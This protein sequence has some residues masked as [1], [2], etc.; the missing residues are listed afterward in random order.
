MI[1]RNNSN[2]QKRALWAV[3]RR[4]GIQ[5]NDKD[6]LDTDNNTKG[7]VAKR[8]GNTAEK[9]KDGRDKKT[10]KV[11][12]KKHSMVKRV[13]IVMA[14]LII[15]S[16][17]VFGYKIISAGDKISVA[18]RSIFAQIK[19][20]F[21][22]QGNVLAGEEEGRINV[23]LIA[24]GGKG[25]KGENLADTIMVASIDPQTN[26]AALL[27][28]PRDLYV[29]VPGRDYYSK[30]NAVHAYGESQK[31][32]NGPVL[33]EGLVEDITGLPIHYYVRV[34]FTAFKSIIDSIGGVN[35]AIDN[36]FFDYWHKIS[37]P[38]GTEKMNGE[39]ALAYVRA[40]YIEGPEGGDF[41]RTARQQQVL[42]AIREKVF[43]VQTAFDFSRLNNILNSLSDNIRTDMQLW[44][45]K[46]FYEMSRL[47]KPKQVHSEVLTSGPK[48]ELTGATE[49]LGGTPASV[50]KPR[51]GDYSEIRAI[52]AS[53]LNEQD[54]VS[55]AE[56][57]AVNNEDNQNNAPS[58]TP[59]NNPSPTPV[60]SVEV[61]KSALEIRNG[62]LITGLAKKTSDDL[63]KQDYEVEKI[64]NAS[65]QERNTTTVYY[66]SSEQE[67]DAEDVASILGAELV[68]SL[69]A[70]VNST[71][72][73]VLIIL[74]YD[75]E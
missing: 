75:Q 21:L 2:S 39:R 69:P 71:S 22:S 51:T 31:E 57:Q 44:E 6:S 64:G 62:T 48:G 55:G 42:L 63:S 8:G 15:L 20:L 7:K 12:R 35:I 41:A 68:N 14:F 32:N 9:N 10:V 3:Q 25:H 73:D 56:K 54:E 5:N 30:I 11:A 58:P 27:S 37:F 26:E 46:R 66:S 67:N 4:Y 24:I 18:E 45:M 65:N 23:L 74:G 52:A 16:I 40:R 43:S 13:F 61:K 36:S 47:I 1:K 53:L 50:L 59:T 28:I 19:D 29:Q 34:D 72:A 70:D 60:E 33:L 38:A 49:I 17:G